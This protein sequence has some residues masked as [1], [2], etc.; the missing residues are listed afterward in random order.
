MKKAFIIALAILLTH[1]SSSA[2][3]L[4][5]D[6]IDGV[7]SGKLSYA[8]SEITLIFRI[9]WHSTLDIP[10]QGIKNLPLKAE[11]KNL[12]RVKFIAGFGGS[13]EGI[14]FRGQI[15]GQYSQNGI[16]LPLILQRGEPPVIR[17][18]TPRSPLPYPTRE[19]FFLSGG[20]TLRGTLSLPAGCDMN[21]GSNAGLISK[22]SPGSQNGPGAKTAAGSKTAA[23]TRPNSGS[24][25]ASGTT[26]AAGANSAPGVRNNPAS[27]TAAKPP[28]VLMVTGSGLQNRDEE[29]LS[30]KPFAVIADAFARNGIATLRYDDRGFGTVTEAAVDATTYTYRDDAA[31]GIEYLRR[32]GFENVGVLGHSE[33]GTIAFMLAADGHPDFII[34]LAGMAERGDTTLFRQTVKMLQLNGSTD[35]EAE[36]YAYLAIGKM[37]AQGGRWGRCFLDLDPTPYMRR[38]KCPTMALSG[39]LDLQVLPDYNIPLIIRHCSGTAATV[40]PG[41]NH[42]FQHAKTG[43][44]VEYGDI[45]E[46][47]AEE[48]IADMIA[49]IRGLFPALF[50][51][52]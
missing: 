41:L 37:R 22:N 30:H 32:Q 25:T 39:S 33:G 38:V 34:S 47:F 48:V 3:S 35:E 2:Q 50:P 43:L 24:K 15:I 20:D 4:G 11:E 12:A 36:R 42:L 49:W 16:T 23:G 31:A 27:A 6:G 9:G 8:S 46:T 45:E 17:P 5:G 14:L 52:D 7:W 21:F 1:L 29:I 40:Y 10:A 13:Y 44:P 51:A 18:Q 26:P 28:V 19:V